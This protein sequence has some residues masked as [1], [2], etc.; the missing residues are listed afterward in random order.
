MLLCHSVDLVPLLKFWLMVVSRCS[1]FWDDDQLRL[2]F[3][4]EVQKKIFSLILSPHDRNQINFIDEAF[5]VEHHPQH[6]SLIYPCGHLLRDLAWSPTDFI[7]WTVILKCC[8]WF[9][10]W[11]YIFVAE[12]PHYAKVWN[13]SWRMSAWILNR[14]MCQVFPVAHLLWLFHLFRHRIYLFDYLPPYFHQGLFSLFELWLTSMHFRLKIDNAG[15]LLLL[16]ASALA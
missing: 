3:F 13:S 2:P 1:C 5:L 16:L 12:K 6:S 9:T 15:I 8:A 14:W 7:T 10:D 4:M 11:I